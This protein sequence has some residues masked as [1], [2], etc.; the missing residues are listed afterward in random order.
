MLPELS[1]ALLPNLIFIDNSIGI[2][3]VDVFNLVAAFRFGIVQVFCVFP[4]ILF[5]FCI[6]IGF[7]LIKNL[8]FVRGTFSAYELLFCFADQFTIKGLW[9]FWCTKG[10]EEEEYGYD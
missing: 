6:N 3:V 2:D 5:P 10:K 4:V 7:S 9:A 1:D 8:D